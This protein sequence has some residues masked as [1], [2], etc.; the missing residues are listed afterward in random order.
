LRLLSLHKVHY[1]KD[2]TKPVTATFRKVERERERERERGRIFHNNLSLK[3]H[4][5]NG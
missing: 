4:H 1:I 3:N 2:K 5:G